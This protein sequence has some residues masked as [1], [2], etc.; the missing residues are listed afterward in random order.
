[1]ERR[2]EVLAR[3]SLKGGA[4]VEGLRRAV[5]LTD[6]TTLEGRDSPGRIRSLCRKALQPA[7]EPGLL[8]PVAA[9]C[10]HPR[11]VALA[12]D[13]LEGSAVRVAS[14][15]TGFP[16]G[17]IPLDLRLAEIERVVAGGASEVDVVLSR[18][19]FLA[20]RLREVEEELRAFRQAAGGACL[21]VILETG[22][23]AGFDAVRLA[24][25]MALAAGA[26]F[27]KT[28]TGKVH[29]AATPAVVLVLLET[30]REHERRTGRRVGV[31]AAGGIRTA[32]QALQYLVLVK[33][34][35]GEAWLRPEL[36]R[37]GASSLVDDLVRQ[38]RKQTLGPYAATWDVPL[39]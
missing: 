31:K 39:G 3:R 19:L 32:K 13:C 27:L 28:S 5:A 36:F 26:D 11:W 10:V 34:T 18:G 1:M 29:P 33:E 30:V 35:V 25:E 24:G 7:G 37:F 22:E 8:P 12:R 38:F 9:V 14:V 4:K 17:Q 16:S 15:A 21:K 6:L 23:L 2:A 20:G